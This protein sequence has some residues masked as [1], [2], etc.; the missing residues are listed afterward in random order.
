MIPKSPQSHEYQNMFDQ[1][2]DKTE[3]CPSLLS[4]KAKV[5]GATYICDDN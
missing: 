1:R 2:F 3:R 4:S 5:Q